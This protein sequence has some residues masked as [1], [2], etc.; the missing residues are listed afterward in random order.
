MGTSAATV[1]GGRVDTGTWPLAVGDVVAILAFVGVGIVNHDGLPFLL[2]NPAQLAFVGLP[3]LIGWAIVAPL[4]GAYSPGAGESAKAAIPLAVRS[5]IAAAVIGL[6]LRATPAFPGDFAVT[7]A[8][9]ALVVGAV[10]L[11]AWRW[12]FFRI[13]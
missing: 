7:F 10:F 9:V 12:L 2:A 5:W 11:G 6:G 4:I 1:L 13:A 3:F 8:V